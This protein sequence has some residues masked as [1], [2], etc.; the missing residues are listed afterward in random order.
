MAASTNTAAR[1]GLRQHFLDQMDE[2]KVIRCIKAS[3]GAA[4]KDLYAGLYEDIYNEAYTAKELK[5]RM[6]G[7]DMTYMGNFFDFEEYGHAFATM[8][9]VFKHREGIATPFVMIL[10]DK[11]EW[12]TE[13]GLV[14]Q[15]INNPNC[16]EIP[17]LKKFSEQVIGDVIV[18]LAKTYNI[19]IDSAQRLWQENPG[20]EQY[21]GILAHGVAA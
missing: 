14:N 18:H 10:T 19:T 15:A 1:I 2:P 17:G 13:M 6:D 11:R 20:K 5:T 3:K 21:F 12:D 8:E 16:I 7:G 4:N 9:Y